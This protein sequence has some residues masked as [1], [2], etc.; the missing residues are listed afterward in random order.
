M[1]IKED[2]IQPYLGASTLVPIAYCYEPNNHGV[3]M[4]C[5]EELEFVFN[6]GYLANENSFVSECYR[7]EHVRNDEII[8]ITRIDEKHIK[9]SVEDKTLTMEVY[10]A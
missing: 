2:L 1:S 3:L 8:K 6:S 7:T 9:V 5:P 4:Y 10:A